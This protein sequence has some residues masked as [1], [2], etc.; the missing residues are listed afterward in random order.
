[1]FRI[2]DMMSSGVKSWSLKLVFRTNSYSG[3]IGV[4]I[5]PLKY[6]SVIC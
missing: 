1:M 5:M 3:G 2:V 6:P 4:R